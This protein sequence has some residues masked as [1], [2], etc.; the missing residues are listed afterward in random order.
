M[1]AR[2]RNEPANTLDE[3]SDPEV[4]D[5]TPLKRNPVQAKLTSPI[6]GE[7][8]GREIVRALLAL[9][10]LLLVFVTVYWSFYATQGR[11]WEA[12]KDWLQS[13]LPAETGVL[14]SV[15]GFYFGSHQSERQRNTSR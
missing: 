7:R 14:G 5:P 12:A 10:A 11:S 2:R 9:A 8:L 13:V 4:P 6:T 3:W 1:P 15:L